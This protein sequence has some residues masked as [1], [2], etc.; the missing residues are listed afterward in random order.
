MKDNIYMCLQFSSHFS[1]LRDAFSPLAE[2]V[3]GIS[4]DWM[5]YL[6]F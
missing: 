6:R 4:D 2:H 1:V 5:D 3:E